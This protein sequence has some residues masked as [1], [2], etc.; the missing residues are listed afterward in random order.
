[1]SLLNWPWDSKAALACDTTGPCR[2]H[3][4]T[5]PSHRGSVRRGRAGVRGACVPRQPG[6]RPEPSRRRRSATARNG[7]ERSTV[8]HCVPPPH[9]RAGHFDIQRVQAQTGHPAHRRAEGPHA[10]LKFRT[11]ARNERDWA[12]RITRL[13]AARGYLASG[14]APDHPDGQL[15]ATGEVVHGTHGL[16]HWGTPGWRS[17]RSAAVSSHNMRPSIIC[18]YK[19]VTSILISDRPAGSRLANPL[20]AIRGIGLCCR[21]N[22]NRR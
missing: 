13:G 10:S 17:R 2:R 1:M 20:D 8:R 11:K 6:T 12:C 14:D 16:A 22:E 21:C 7:G 9:Y 18:K 19:P 3:R 5:R 4:R 15:L